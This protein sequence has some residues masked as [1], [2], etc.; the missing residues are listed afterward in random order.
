MIRPARFHRLASERGTRFPYRLS[1][2]RCRG[3]VDISFGP[4]IPDPDPRARD[5]TTE[6]LALEIAPHR[7][8]RQL[9]H[10]PRLAR[11]VQGTVVKRCP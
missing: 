4:R 5:A 10:D 8:D 9:R 2:G 3:R 6:H 1:P 11:L 7:L